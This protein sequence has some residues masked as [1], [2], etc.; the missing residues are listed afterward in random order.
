M[1]YLGSLTAAAV[2]ALASLSPALAA[3]NET[4]RGAAPNHTVI[5]TFRLEVS[6]Q[7]S[8]RATFWVAYGPLKG[9]WGLV[10]LRA[11]RSGVYQGSARLPIPGKTTFAFIEGQ[12]VVHTAHGPVPGDLVV[13]IKRFDHVSTTAPQLGLVQWQAPVG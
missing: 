10:R 11:T 12:G 9:Q 1:R 8:P 2:L 7:V 6:N 13:T 5:R 3:S 4:S